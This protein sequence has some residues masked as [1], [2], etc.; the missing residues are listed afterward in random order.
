MVVIPHSDMTSE[1]ASI[2]S[3]LEVIANREQIQSTPMMLHLAMAISD[4]FISK[5]RSWGLD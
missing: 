3:A 5:F 2:T 1:V 4:L